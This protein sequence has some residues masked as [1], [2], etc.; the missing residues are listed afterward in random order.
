MS[1]KFEV[2]KEVYQRG[3]NFFKPINVE[4]G[5]QQVYITDIPHANITRGAPL[6]FFIPGTS[7]DYLALQWS[8][9]FVKVR[10]TDENNTPITNLDKVGPVN[11]LFHSLFKQVDVTVG[12][13]LVTPTVD[14]YYHYK[15]YFDTLLGSDTVS[16]MSNLQSALWYKD[17]PGVFDDTDVDY[18]LNLGLINRSTFTDGGAEVELSGPLLVEICQQGK[19]LINGVKVRIKMYPNSDEFLLMCTDLDR[20]YRVEIT[21]A[22]YKCCYVKP[23]PGIIIEQQETLNEKIIALYP[24]TKSHYGVTQIAKGLSQHSDTNMFSG[25]VPEQVYV[26]FTSSKASDGSYQK[27]GYNFTHNNCSSV[28][29][30]VENISVPGKPLS[31]NYDEDQYLEGYNS[32]FIG[33]RYSSDSKGLSIERLDYPKGNA[34]YRFAITPPTEKTEEDQ[35]G[36]V[37]NLMKKGNVTFTVKF[38]QPLLETV[39]CHVYAKFPAVLQVDENKAVT[40]SS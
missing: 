2:S 30:Q 8:R 4:I 21:D 25:A 10:I 39:S 27:N 28:E 20:K 34:I 32:L 18:G 19:F 12:G 17:T 6:E 24:F 31:M 3:F 11:N 37:T 33:G 36:E 16:Q 15:A 13:Q 29:I 38:S 1:Y 5:T 22:V 26:A 9:L 14:Q 7:R 40:I 35:L 23:D